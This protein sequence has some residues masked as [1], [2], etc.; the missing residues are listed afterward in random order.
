MKK[1]LS[2]VL[3]LVM[4]FGCVGLVACGCEEEE[5]TP[6]ATDGGASTKSD[7]G[8]PAP[9]DEEEE[10]EEEEPASSGGKLTWKDMPVYHGADQIH[11]LSMTIPVT[12]D[13][14]YSEVEQHY[15]TTDDDTEDVVDF[16]KDEMPD[17][18]W[19]EGQW[20]ESTVMN[21][22]FYTKNNEEDMAAVIIASGEDEDETVIVL[23]RAAK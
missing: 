7:G 9:S 16:Y 14:E 13:E 1:L 23:M 18:G 11:E 20:V 8:A 2:L 19:G 22:G 17:N 12:E 3:V 4:V 5:E 21:W 6:A 10:E 15:Y